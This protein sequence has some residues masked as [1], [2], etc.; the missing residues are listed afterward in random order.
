[1]IK[2]TTSW[3]VCIYGILLIGLGLLAYQKS[4]SRISLY[5]GLAFGFLLILCA[6]LMFAKNRFGGYAAVLI[7]LLLTGTFAYRYTVVQK[8]VPAIL[9]VLSGGVLLFLLFHMVRRKKS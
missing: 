6:L 3:T 8:P 1:M 2:K 4:E 5:M 7:T 9:A